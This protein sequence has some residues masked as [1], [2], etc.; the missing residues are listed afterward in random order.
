MYFFIKVILVD[1]RYIDWAELI[2]DRL[3]ETYYMSSYLLYYLACVRLWAGLYHEA[4]VDG[5]K[6]YE[7]YPHLQ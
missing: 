5:M 4:W 2:E 3:H 1:N 7:Y 6:I